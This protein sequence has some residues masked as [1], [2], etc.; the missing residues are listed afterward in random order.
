M[1]NIALLQISA[2][3]WDVDENL[4]RAVDACR[5]AAAMGAHIA[6]LPECFSTGYVL[7]EDDSDDSRRRLEDAAIDTDHD[8]VRS[9][10]ELARELG[11]AI[12]A[13]YLGRGRHGPRNSVSVI[14]HRGEVRLTYSKCHTCDFSD[15]AILEPGDGFPVAKVSTGAG[16]V[17][18]GCMICYDR[19][20]PESARALMLG[21]AEVVLVPNACDLEINRLSQFRARAFENMMALAMANYPAPRNNGHSVAYD[22]IAF[23]EVDGDPRDMLVVEAGEAEG[24]YM[25][26]VDLEALRDYRSRETWGDAYRKPKLYGALTENTPAPPFVRS[27]SRR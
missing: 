1:L 17:K 19:E 27:D 11:L 22:G 18:V 20:F 12:G 4:R 26:P 7:P 16:P 23:L 15:E 21:G 5:R 24:V 13:T 6:L 3:P 8:Y 2:A 14:D 9:L 25:A 10:R